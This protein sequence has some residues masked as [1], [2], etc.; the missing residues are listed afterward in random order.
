MNSNIGFPKISKRIQAVLIDSIIITVCFITTMIGMSLL[1]VQGINS[2]IL[3]GLIVC[4]LEPAMIAFTGGSIGHHILSLRVINKDTQNNVGLISAF[5]RFF[6]KAILGLF[7]IVSIFTTK[8]YQAIHDLSIGSIVVLKDPQA[9]QTHEVLSERVI[10]E[11]GYMYPSKTRRVIMIF[12]YNLVLFIVLELLL[13]FV[14]SSACLGTMH[15]SNFENAV[16]YGLSILWI[17]T[18]FVITIYCWKGLVPG[19]HRVVESK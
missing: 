3:A 7:S 14:L 9:L 12:L 19:C 1:G 2:I 8:Q 4:I 16:A 15:C 5:I 11:E 10:E 13:V 17:V 18:N 6:L